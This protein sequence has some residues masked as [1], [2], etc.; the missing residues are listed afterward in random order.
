MPGAGQLPHTE[1]LR[2]N[3]MSPSSATQTR[4]T[5]LRLPTPET[6]PPRTALGK[7][8]FRG[9][10]LDALRVHERSYG[11]YWVIWLTGVDYFSSLAYQ[12][13]IALLAAGLLSPT[14]TLILVA[15]TLLGALPVY[16]QVAGRS[17]AGQGSIAMLENLLTGWK[18][19]ILVLVLLGFAATD[20]VITM[21]L[22]AADAARHA[23]ANPY[24]KT[25]LGHAQLGLTLFLLLVLAIIFLIGFKEAIR[26]ATFVAIP[27]MLLNLVVIV[28][29]LLRI[30][31]HPELASHWRLAMSMHTDW[32]SIA[33]ASALVFPKLALGLSGFETGVAVMPLVAGEKEIETADVPAGRIRNT[34]KLL[35]AAAV[36]MGVYLI[37]SSFAT[38]ILIPESAYRVGGPAS[39]RALA[40]LAHEILGNIFGTVYDLSTIAILWFAG[41][42]AMAGLINLIPRYLPRF[43]MAPHWVSYR[44]PMVVV[45]FA[46]DVIVTLVFKA[47]VEAQGSAYATGV[48]V[49]ILSAAVAVS[50]ALWREYQTGRRIGG[51]ALALSVF[52]WAVSLLFVYTVIANVIERPDG[53]IISSIFIAVILIFSALSRYQRAKELRVSELTFIN[54]SS[55]ALWPVLAGK[56]V[57]LV[58]IREMDRAGRIAKSAEILGHYHVTGPIA[59]LH[60]N[61]LDNRS[62]FIAPLRIRIRQEDGYFVLDVWGAVALANTIAYL[63]ELL[64]PIALFLDLTGQNLMSQAAKYMLWGEGETAL[65]VYTILLHYWEWAGKTR[66]RPHLHLMSP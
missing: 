54:E 26:V 34:R 22:S 55:A 11:W 20:F 62:E 28:A 39:G 44:R 16:V 13:G 46:I 43:G 19:K 9:G 8:F 33:I 60:V 41:A 27:F 29:G 52:F 49:L 65:M 48:L 25:Y 21:P 45:L 10:R 35:A 64:D 1:P 36:I 47:N 24:L 4:A 51:K 5:V 2:A 31:A 59:F 30:A 37:F 66:D 40:Y 56:R 7:W 61:L 50:L 58:P 32:T 18:S 3:D 38:T 6:A 14:A 53:V 17:Y 15:V 12:P 23:V 57:N 42:S 63:T